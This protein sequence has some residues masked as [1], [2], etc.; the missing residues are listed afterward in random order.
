M[1]SSQNSTLKV[2]HLI[3]FHYLL[4]PLLILLNKMLGHFIIKSKR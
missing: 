2:N 3:S 4:S 1:M